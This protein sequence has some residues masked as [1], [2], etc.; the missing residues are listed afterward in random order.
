MRHKVFFDLYDH[1]TTHKIYDGYA[2][3]DRDWIELGY[4]PRNEIALLLQKHF[5]S[6]YQVGNFR[7]TLK[8]V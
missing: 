4:G 3:I 2:T 6:D 5:M 8:K 1:K 7:N